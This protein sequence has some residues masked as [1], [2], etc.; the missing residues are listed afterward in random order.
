MV[1]KIKFSTGA[2][3]YTDYRGWQ[4]WYRP[5][6]PVTGRWGAVQNGVELGTTTP[7]GV[8]DMIDHR[9]ADEQE[10]RRGLKD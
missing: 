6:A 9:I 2:T 8:R 1:S 5:A 4:L 3:K 7:Q 10:R